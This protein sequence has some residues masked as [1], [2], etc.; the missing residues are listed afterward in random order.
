M[1][2][3]FSVAAACLPLM[4]FSSLVDAASLRIPANSSYTVP[5]TQTEMTLD[6]LM[7]GD[8][9]T[10]SFAPGVV[11]WDLRAAK[12]SIGEG[13]IVDAAGAAG[14][15]GEDGADGKSCSDNSDGQGGQPGSAGGNAISVS[16][17]LGI[18]EIGSLAINASGGRGGN[19]G[20]GGAGAD[21]SERCEDVDAGS[22][23]DG[24]AGG[25]G[26]EGGN[27]RVL[28]HRLSSQLNADNIEN[29]IAITAEPGASGAGGSP[30][31]GGEG[32]EGRYVQAR[33]LTGSRKWV[34]GADSGDNGSE[35]RDGLRGKA[36]QAIIAELEAAVTAEESQFIPKPA[37]QSGGVSSEIKALRLELE[38][39]RRRVEA[40]EAR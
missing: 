4:C 19:G 16:L 30:G 17:R 18:T 23:G 15:D 32:G 27:V 31:S 36:G 20:A 34:G 22:G 24:G 33:T 21:Y 37:K 40:L 29:S 35:G 9:A 25:A 28:Y 13:V 2:R 12:A 26:G 3:V 6:E 10:I 14:V 7:I 39:L 8:G 5:V 11:A 38:A 1:K